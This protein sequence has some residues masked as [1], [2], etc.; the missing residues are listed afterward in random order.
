MPR[1]VVPPVRFRSSG[2][3]SGVGGDGLPERLVK[4]V[5][6]ETLAFFV[7]LAAVIGPDR[8][9]LL[10]ALLCVGLAGTVGYLWLAGQKTAA[11]ERPLPHF[12]ALAAVAYLCWALATSPHAA[13]LLGL[14]QVEAGVVL[15]L[16]VF[17]VPLAD[18]LLVRLRRPAG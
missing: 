10:I 1:T 14:D 3:N 2:A 16:A 9:P 7:P 5:P 11:D 13:A 8:R 15:T 17:L 4:Y 12:Y 6:A 18:E